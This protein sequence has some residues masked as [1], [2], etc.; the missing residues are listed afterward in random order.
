MNYLTQETLLLI[1]TCIAMVSMISTKLLTDRWITPCLFY[2]GVWIMAIIANLVTTALDV[3]PPITLLGCELILQAHLGTLIG[4]AYSGLLLK[5]I[6]KGDKQVIRPAIYESEAYYAV[7]KWVIISLT[8]ITGG[9]LLERISSIG[10]VADFYQQVRQAYLFESKSI[11]TRISFWALPL[12]MVFAVTLG[13]RA[14]ANIRGDNKLLIGIIVALIFASISSGSRIIIFTFAGL[15]IFGRLILLEDRAQG[16][17]ISYIFKNFG[18]QAIIGFAILVILFQIMHMWRA[19]DPFDSRP[20][21]HLSYW[22]PAEFAS[23]MALPAAALGPLVDTVDQN[24]RGYG[25]VLFPFMGKILSFGGVA[26][27]PV[28]ELDF[29]NRQILQDNDMRIG[30]VQGT[31]IIGMVADFGRENVWLTSALL[32]STTQYLFLVYVK[33]GLTGILIASQACF[34][35]FFSFQDAWFFNS[36]I[37][38]S[39]LWAYYL[40]R[41][42]NSVIRKNNNG[43]VSG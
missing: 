29:V 37:I 27:E 34:A 20:D 38:L 25:Q 6:S 13:A 35:T 28:V 2:W 43:Y 31:A 39:L 42:I 18:K 8:L 36:N 19:A 21:N 4:F 23:Y 9:V 24:K 30:W 26:W 41:K 7:A 15:Y 22:V 12:Y 17:P 16:A 10:F 33:R 5:M 14:G 3:L 32:M 1:T 11:L 40:S